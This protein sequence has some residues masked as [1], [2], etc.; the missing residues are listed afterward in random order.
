MD[1]RVNIEIDLDNLAL[2]EV[3]EF[4]RDRVTGPDQ[5]FDDDELSE[6]ALKHGWVRADTNKKTDGE[7][8]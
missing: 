8:E 2:A 1:G 4:V 6:W 7:G 3:I 5:V